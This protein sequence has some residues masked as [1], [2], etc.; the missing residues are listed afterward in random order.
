MALR[1][2]PADLLY[3]DEDYVNSA[4]A[5]EQPN[6]KPA[7]SPEMLLSCMYLGHLLVISRA[8]LEQMGGFRS[9]FDGAQDH[10]AALRLLAEG[11]KFRHLPL[12]LYHWRR[13]KGSTAQSSAAK[14]Y[15]H[16]AGHRAIQEYLDQAGCQAEVEDGIGPNTH[17]VRW[18]AP[19]EIRRSIIVPSR[20]P[21]LLKRCL[22]R[23]RA[24][25][26]DSNP[27]I[28][29]VHHF[30]SSK[31]DREIEALAE[32]HRCRRMVYAG[33]FNYSRMCNLGA[34]AATGDCL[35]FIND[36]AWPVEASWLDRM[37]GH[38]GRPDVGVVGALL[39][40]PDGAIQ[41]AGIALG[42]LH[43]TGHIG[44]F[45]FDSHLFPWINY[46]RDVSAVS[47]ACLS[48]RRDVF[49]RCGGFDTDFPRSFNDIDLCLRVG[50]AGLAVIV[51]RTVELIHI[52]QATR[53]SGQTSQERLLFLSRW[54][55]QVLKRDPC[56]SPHLSLDSE[57]P[58][59]SSEHSPWRSGSGVR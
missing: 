11:G 42:M 53:P 44:R 45:L 3:T 34:R 48:I 56:L 31:R 7:F 16:D 40:Y 58:V 22:E 32:L 4:G 8:R 54:Y 13:H 27:E 33:D 18:H 24:T 23:L 20:T 46:S 30:T 38:L 10:D 21:A 15:A 29:V 36:D 17:Q 50:E 52:E 14:P 47:G 19:P 41:H 28:V 57:Q 1:Q 5:P 49:E 59:L 6:F 39:R 12:V 51:D 9:R 55:S 37:A 26:A 2:E 25:T 35:V 43:A